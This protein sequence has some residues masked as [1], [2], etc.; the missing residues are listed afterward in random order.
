MC[1]SLF[2]YLFPS[3]PLP[4]SLYTLHVQE[5][6]QWKGTHPLQGPGARIP[7]NCW[8]NCRRNSERSGEF[9][10]TPPAL[11]VSLAV[12][13][14][15]CPHFHGPCQ[16]PSFAAKSVPKGVERRESYQTVIFQITQKLPRG[17][18]LRT[19]YR[20]RYRSETV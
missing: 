17:N 7:E 16:P 13:P 6:R 2:C 5:V 3:L 8:G 15:V 18:S 19:S 14:A 1:F 4:L 9:W 12:S 10:G 20:Y 11:R